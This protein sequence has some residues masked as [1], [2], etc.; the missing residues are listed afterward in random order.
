MSLTQGA[1]SG[2]LNLVPESHKAVDTD[3]KRVQEIYKDIHERPGL[4]FMETRTAGIVAEE[5]RALGFEV[6]TGIGK[7]GVAGILRSG[8]GPVFMFRGESDD[9]VT[10]SVRTTS[11]TAARAPLL[12][13]EDDDH[14]RH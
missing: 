5:M 11:E 12:R 1:N 4:G 2:M 8:D 9:A 14:H 7:T 6:R 10:R 13:L 3:A